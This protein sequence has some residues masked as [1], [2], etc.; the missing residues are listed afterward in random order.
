MKAPFIV[1][2]GID[3]SGKGT[4]IRLLGEHFS[5]RQIPWL[6]TREPGGVPSAEKIRNALLA[7]QIKPLGPIAEVMLF[8]AARTHHLSELIR[9][10]L[11][12][13]TTVI[14]D[15]FTASTLAYQ[16]AGA[17]IDIEWLNT[18]Q[19]VIVGDTQ[20]DEV[21]VLD[22]PV[23]LSIQRQKARGSA[24]DRFESEKLE[25]HEKLRQK[26]RDICA[27]NPSTYSLINGTLPP[28]QIH[29]SILK[30]ISRHFP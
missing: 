17:G 14:C 15:R 24:P 27:R 3:A 2:E 19:D 7:G 30:K 23:A 18:L 11:Q 29:A 1:I 4:Q 16:G 12:H 26:Y 28:E 6:A 25:F 8:N 21:I 10:A 20:P 13:G 5:R 22:I 9:P